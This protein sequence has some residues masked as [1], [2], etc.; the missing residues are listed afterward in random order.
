MQ[1]KGAI[2]ESKVSSIIA[3]I[4][5]E[6]LSLKDRMHIQKDRELKLTSGSREEFESVQKQNQSVL[7]PNSRKDQSGGVE[8][9]G[10]VRQNKGG[11]IEEV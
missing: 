5:Q 4:D 7:S 9:K 11:E 2:V 6:L 1:S 3:S 10:R 8:T